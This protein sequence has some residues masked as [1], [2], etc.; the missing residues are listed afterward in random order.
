M[1]AVPEDNPYKNDWWYEQNQMQFD[2]DESDWMAAIEDMGVMA[3]SVYLLGA[4]ASTILAVAVAGF[5]I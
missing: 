5:I 4:K 3:E 2:N 1:A